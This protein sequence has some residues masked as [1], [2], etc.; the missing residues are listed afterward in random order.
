MMRLRTIFPLVTM[1]FLAVGAAFTVGVLFQLRTMRGDAGAVNKTG[2]MRGASQR[3]MKME[4]AHKPA[5]KIMAL[6]E[7]TMQTLEQGDASTGFARITDMECRKQLVVL[8]GAFERL[9]ETVQAFRADQVGVDELV[10]VSE[11]LWDTTNAV[12]NAFEKASQQKLMRFYRLVG[13]FIAIMVLLSV[14]LLLLGRQVS[15]AVEKVGLRLGRVA[16]LD[17]RLQDEKEGSWR[18]FQLRDAVQLT[19]TVTRMTGA[20]EAMVQ[21]LQG[22]SRSVADSG[23]VVSQ[24]SEQLAESTNEETALIEQLTQALSQSQEAMGQLVAQVEQSSQGMEANQQETSKSL[25][26]LKQLV[27]HVETMAKYSQEIGGVADRTHL[28][29]LNASIEAARAGQAGAGF[30]VVAR[31][32]TRLADQ[33]AEAA[34]HIA[35][36][37]RKSL[38]LSQQALQSLEALPKTLAQSSSLSESVEQTCT[39]QQDMLDHIHGNAQE[40]GNLVQ[41]NAAHAE[42]LAGQAE[43]AQGFSD[44]LAHLVG[45]FTLNDTTQA[46]QEAA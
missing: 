23:Q 9:K 29:S 3:M 28:L 21:E 24:T 20:L 1:L 26:A 27:T 25:E 38:D 19:R 10:A 34:G 33:S 45:R 2:V 22:T 14:V 32:V 18:G 30:S 39:Q 41:G 44:S 5:D 16:T 36:L 37:V 46:P 43:E 17:L 31:E 35:S 11:Q 12:V 7:K 6:L 4:L 42:E 15:R 13:G 40:L 8:R